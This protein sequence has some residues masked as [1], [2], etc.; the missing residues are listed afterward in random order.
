M[1]II[2]TEGKNLAF[3]DLLSRQFPI[4][5]AKKFQ[6]EHKTIPKN[7]NIY[8]S[9]LKPVSYSVLHK[10]DKTNSSDD[11]YPILA[12]V[13]GGTRKVVIISETDFSIYDAPEGFTDSCNAIHNIADYFKFGKNINQIVKLTESKQSDNIYSEIQEEVNYVELDDSGYNDDG[14][15][16]VIDNLVDPILIHAPEKAKEIYKERTKNFT[17]IESTALH[18]ENVKSDGSDLLTKLTEFAKKAQ[19]YFDTIL[20]EQSKD[21]V[22]HIVRK[23]I[24]PGNEPEHYYMTRLCKALK[25]YK[26]I[27]KLLL[28]DESYELLCYNKPN[29]NGSFEL[30]ICIPISLFLKCFVL[31]HSNPMSGHRGDAITLNNISRF[32]YWPEMYKWVT[33]LIHN[34]LY[35]QKNKSKRHELNKA[36]LQ[37]WV[38]LETNPFHTIHIDHKGP[39][40]PSS[41]GKHYCLV[42]VDS[43]SRYVQVY[44]INS[45]ETMKQMEKFITSFGIL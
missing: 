31:V 21:P 28:P 38:E 24:E 20:Q 15:S 13:H 40:R 33:M 37:Q 34:C 11:S 2:Y 43:F 41:N 25:A 1:E 7:V 29:V 27:Y 23:W 5:E 22:L 3:P 14:F 16:D 39:F 17:I 26:S 35:C 8:T 18:N 12:Q 44:A 45:D 42:V 9:D 6:I 36:P 10:E 32:F 19:L 30:K 4:E